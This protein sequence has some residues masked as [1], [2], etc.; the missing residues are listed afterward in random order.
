MFEVMDL[1]GRSLPELKEI[2]KAFA[3]DSK[4]LAKPDLVLRIV[5]AQSVN[6]DLAREIA[7]KFSKREKD[8]RIPRETRETREARDFREKRPRK[9]K[10]EPFSE[11]S[12][13]DTIRETQEEEVIAPAPQQEE[14]AAE[15]KQPSAESID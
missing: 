7:G 10:L 14:S 11:E 13:Q 6:T 8:A 9:V 3:I 2:A 15:E 5:D 4:G 12:V 1:S